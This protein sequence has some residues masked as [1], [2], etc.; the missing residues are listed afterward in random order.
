MFGDLSVTINW[1]ILWF[2]SYVA[3]CKVFDSGVVCSSS[4]EYPR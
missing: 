1:I 2:W 4:Y 3:P